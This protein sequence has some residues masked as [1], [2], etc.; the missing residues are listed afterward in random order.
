MAG[1]NNWMVY[2]TDDGIQY[3]VNVAES[4]AIAG[5]FDDYTADPPL[6]PLP[7]GF[8]MRTVQVVD[9]DAGSTRSLPVGKPDGPIWQDAVAALLLPWF[10]AQGPGLGALVAFLITSFTGEKRRGRPN[11]FETGLDDGYLG[12]NPGGAPPEP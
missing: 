2:T 10:S 9:Q 7:K 5:D 12:G 11:P 6:P 4:N 8:V 1:S 3:A